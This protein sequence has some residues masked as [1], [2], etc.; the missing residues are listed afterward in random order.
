MASV[1]S[2]CLVLCVVLLFCES[3]HSVVTEYFVASINHSEIAGL[4][5]IEDGSI[6]AMNIQRKAPLKKSK[7]L[8][9]NMHSDEIIYRHGESETTLKIQKSMSHLDAWSI[10]HPLWNKPMKGR[11][12]SL[13][14]IQSNSDDIVIINTQIN[15]NRMIRIGTRAIKAIMHETFRQR[16]QNETSQFPLDQV[17]EN[18]TIDSY[19]YKEGMRS[20]AD[21]RERVI[22]WSSIGLLFIAC[23][24]AVIGWRMQCIKYKIYRDCV[25][26]VD[27]HRD[28]QEIERHEI[29]IESSND[30]SE[31]SLQDTQIVAAVF[32]PSSN[33][34]NN[35]HRACSCHENV[36]VCPLTFDMNLNQRSLS[37]N[38]SM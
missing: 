34:N 30:R 16:R 24:V 17:A 13:D 14:I 18:G 21:W 12:N 11:T 27:T 5:R 25:R 8:H 38:E 15:V 2:Q 26:P 3:T 28:H 33:S 4:Y 32:E 37:K 6:L 29:K 10:K 31:V 23:S 1:C 22:Y 9:N 19:M 36:V 20:R 7:R 35:E